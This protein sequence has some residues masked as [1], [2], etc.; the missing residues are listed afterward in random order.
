MASKEKVH[1]TAHDVMVLFRDLVKEKGRQYRYK[2]EHRLCRNFDADAFGHINTPSCIVGHVLAHYGLTYKQ[3][4]NGTL[5]STLMVISRTAPH[6]TFTR[7]AVLILAGAQRI[8]DEGGTWGDCYILAK[9]IERFE[10][11]E[12]QMHLTNVTESGELNAKSRLMVVK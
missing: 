7:D 3:C 5:Q 1:V 2:S 4:S 8:Q 9:A 6:I 10:T 12:A 11:F